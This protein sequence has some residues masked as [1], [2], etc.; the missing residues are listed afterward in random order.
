MY[1]WSNISI[2]TAVYLHIPKHLCIARPRSA[3][4][5]TFHYSLE[6]PY[7]IYTST[8]LFPYKSTRPVKKTHLP[9]LTH[10]RDVQKRR[11]SSP[12]RKTAQ[13]RVLLPPLLRY[14]QI[15]HRRPRFHGHAGSAAN[16]RRSNWSECVGKVVR[17]RILR[18]DV[19]SDQH[20]EPVEGNTRDVGDQGAGSTARNL[21]GV[22]W[23]QY[24]RLVY[25]HRFH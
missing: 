15:Q 8:F 20:A 21:D 18:F 7:C 4:H 23:V 16:K 6:T 3:T 2:A 13:K 14:I 5:H 9:Q 10:A 25:V 11:N 1:I 17:E 22:C 19:L 12:R 24:H